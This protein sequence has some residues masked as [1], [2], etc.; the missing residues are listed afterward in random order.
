MDPDEQGTG[1]PPESTSPAEGEYEAMVVDA[2]WVVHDGVPEA[3][4]LSVTVTS[5]ELKG[6]VVDMRFAAGTPAL[7][8]ALKAC[9]VTGG[10]A[11]GDPGVCSAV[12]AMPCTLLVAHDPQRGVGLALTPP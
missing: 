2:G 5:G 7:D 4:S 12:L 10:T 3:L 11:P 1:S 8:S 9:G 6:Y